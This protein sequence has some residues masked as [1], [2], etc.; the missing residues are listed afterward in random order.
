MELYYQRSVMPANKAL[1]ILFVKFSNSYLMM[2][3]MKKDQEKR[4]E[5]YGFLS[6]Y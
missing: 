1:D 3:I 5:S 6:V 2:R 4:L